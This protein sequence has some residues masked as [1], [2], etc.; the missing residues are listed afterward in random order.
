MGRRSDIFLVRH[1]ETDWNVEDRFQ[2]QKDSAL[3]DRGRR[4]AVLVGDRLYGL[5]GERAF[6]LLVSPLGRAQETARIVASRFP[7]AVSQIV[8]PRLVEVTLGAWDGLTMTDID[9]L[10]PGALDGS[11]PFDWYF[12]APDGES[13]EAAQARAQEWLF[14]VGTVAGPVIAI[15]HGLTGRV[16]RGVFAG[17]DQGSMLRVPVSQ[18]VVWQLHDGTVTEIEL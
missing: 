2:G 4:Q 5:L 3:T 11:D 15:S 14:D 9:A 17:L 16:I 18:S 1:G 12:R 7:V 8:D 6:T 13:F 10:W